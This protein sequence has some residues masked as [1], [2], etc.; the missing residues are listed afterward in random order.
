MNIVELAKK[1][2]TEAHAGQT[3]WGGEPYIIHPEAVAADVRQTLEKCF[4]EDGGGGIDFI[5]DCY[6]SQGHTLNIKEFIDVCEALGY[7]HDVW[8]DQEHNYPYVRIVEIF[9]NNCTIPDNMVDAL[10]SGIK[11]ITKNPIKG[12]ETYLTYIQRVKANGFARL[13]K[14]FDIKHN[15]SDLKP[16]AMRDKYELAKYILMHNII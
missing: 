5:F 10:L 3:R 15:M 11:A 16:G 6:D 2:A 9:R 12:A 4:A 13:V 1:V 7:M 14:V 8:E